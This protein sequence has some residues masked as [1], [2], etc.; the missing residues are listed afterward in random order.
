MA[1]TIFYAYFKQIFLH[2]YF[3]PLFHAYFSHKKC[4]KYANKI[5][6]NASHSI[7]KGHL[8]KKKQQSK[9]SESKSLFCF[10]FT[11]IFAKCY[12]NELIVVT[13]I[14][15]THLMSAVLA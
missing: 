12:L 5:H 6:M 14:C 8:I 11:R 10:Q 13:I 3:L 9:C 7:S 2:A 15:S 4:I 1:Q